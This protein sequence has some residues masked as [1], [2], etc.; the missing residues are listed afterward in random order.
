MENDSASLVSGFHFV[1]EA[2]PPALMR[3][4]ALGNRFVEVSSDLLDHSIRKKFTKDLCLLLETS[5]LYHFVS[6][7]L[8]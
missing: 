1:D 3:A 8:E 2:T 5:S 4:L 6:G 7:G